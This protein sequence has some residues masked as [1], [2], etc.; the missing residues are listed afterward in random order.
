MDI[1]QTL[2]LPYTFDFAGR[3]LKVAEREYDIHGMF[4]QYVKQRTV[5]EIE[6]QRATLP[7][8][9]YSVLWEKYLDKLTM[10]VYEFGMPI[11]TA[12]AVSPSG[13]KYLALLDLA[14]HNDGIDE[15]FV[16]KLWSDAA[17]WDTFCRLRQVANDPNREGPT[18]TE[19]VGP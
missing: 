10:G 16:E 8:H 3:K 17:A 6:R 12:A 11:C 1:S 9:A 2:N 4:S 19:A 7:A 18:A 13:A 14:R 5:E 15:A